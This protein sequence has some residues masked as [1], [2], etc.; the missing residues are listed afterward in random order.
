[1]EKIQLKG[2]E[3][4]YLKGSLPEGVSSKCPRCREERFLDEI[5]SEQ[6]V[7]CPE[8]GRIASV[9]IIENT[10]FV[11]WI[12]GIEKGRIEISSLPELPSE[13]RER[14][15]KE[16]GLSKEE[17]D[18]LSTV[19]GRAKIFED[20][21]E[22]VPAGVASTFVSDALAR[23]LKIRDMET[24]DFK[25]EGIKEL[26]KDYSQDKITE[27]SIDKII[28]KSLEEDKPVYQVYEPEKYE[29]REKEDLR[30]VCEEVVDEEKEAVQDFLEGKED[31]I[32]YLI[33]MVKKKTEGRADAQ[34][35]REIIKEILS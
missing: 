25:R 8:C 32:N 2:E 3:A 31:S 16:Y 23:E 21:A 33:G 15:K 30:Q 26:L 24:S 34:E 4:Y 6:G 9:K 29:K 19:K 27:D 12:S 13:L 14:L 11:S 20:I 1:M 35:A 18:K 10:G 28:R 5:V 17:S 22:E 7:H